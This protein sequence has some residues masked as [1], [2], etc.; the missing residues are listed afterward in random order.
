MNPADRMR[1]FEIR[2]RGKTGRY[3][4]PDENAFCERMLKA[5]PEEYAEVSEEIRRWAMELMNPLAGKKA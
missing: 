4:S 5:H 2:Q 3:V 1:L